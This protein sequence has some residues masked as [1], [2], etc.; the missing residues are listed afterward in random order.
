MTT[1]LR[2]VPAERRHLA[3]SLAPDASDVDAVWWELVDVSLPPDRLPAAVALTRLSFD[4][5]VRVLV[6]APPVPRLVRELVAALRRTDALALEVASGGGVVEALSCE[7]VEYLGD[8]L[9]VRF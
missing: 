2:R 6:L 3:R 5:V 7:D 8:L 9:V 1:V 4:G